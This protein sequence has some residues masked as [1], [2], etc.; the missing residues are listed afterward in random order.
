MLRKLVILGVCAGSA[1]S[2]PTIY[3]ANPELFDLLPR[4]AA[5]RSAELDPAPQI[6]LASVPDRPATTPQ[7]G[8]RKVTV[9][10]DG[11]GHFLATF[12]LNGLPVNAMIDTGATMVA[13]NASTARKMG[14]P[15]QLSDFNRQI[16]TANGLAKAAVIQIGRLEIGRIAV[17]DVQAIVL[18]DKSLGGTLIGMNF[19]KR[20]GRYQVDNGTLTLI[21]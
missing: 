18:D 20:L 15:L 21:Q 11:R 16:N 6:N 1:A 12:K 4:T 14:I 13:I 17:S 2:V 3:Q 19:L 9:S 7:T 10:A 5:Q 8:G